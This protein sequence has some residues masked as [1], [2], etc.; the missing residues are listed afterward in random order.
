M[1]R[2]N[3]IVVTFLSSLVACSGAPLH[4]RAV[5]HNAAAVDLIG[6]GD[7]DGAR[8]NLEVA[9]EY[10]P[11]FAEA[12]ANKGLI[13]LR[14]G[15]LAEGEGL[16]RRAV[17]LNPDF[18]EAWTNLAS[19]SLYRNDADE[20]L[21]RAKR[22]VR[23]DPAFAEARVVLIR[24]LVAKGRLDEAREQVRRL[25]VVRP[26]E[27]RS[28]ALEGLVLFVDGDEDA[29]AEALERALERDVDCTLA[30]EVRGRLRLSRGRARQAASDLQAASS[31]RPEDPDL[32]YF[33]A[34]SLL[35]SNEA[36][37]A[38]AELIRLLD[39]HPA[40]ARG[41]TAMA[42][43]EVSRGDFGRARTLLDRARAARPDLAEIR[44]VRAR[45]PGSD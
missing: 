25:L 42:L 9:L 20:A 8:A 17:T 28:H 14:S 38:T 6:E 45:L 22:A 37:R 16:F 15:R 1:K 26:D 40:H 27:A 34:L 18:A 33:L 7:L 10:N 21:S 30:L 24:V 5:E 12:H 36:E 13:A 39:D 44:A 19:I 32:R 23:V 11:R 2:T 4:D 41:L 43:I 31:A 3:P 35:G 29:A